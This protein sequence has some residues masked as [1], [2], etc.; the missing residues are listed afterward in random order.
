MTKDV[1]PAERSRMNA[2]IQDLSAINR[3]NRLHSDS[4][5]A[6][7][8]NAIHIELKAEY[9]G[10]ATRTREVA[11]ER[12]AKDRGAKGVCKEPGCGMPRADGDT[13][14]AGHARLMS[15]EPGR[16]IAAND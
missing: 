10:Y 14:C 11:Q 6:G 15:Y 8:L 13:Y 16:E 9:D 2:L 4:N 5:V 7:V 1:T 3:V 12:M